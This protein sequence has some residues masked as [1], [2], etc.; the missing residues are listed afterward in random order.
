VLKGTP[1]RIVAASLKSVDEVMAVL[2]AGA[3][4]VTIPLDL[5][6]KLAEHELSQQAIRDFSAAAKSS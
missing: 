5:I 6:F 4:D 3:H 1:T 2:I